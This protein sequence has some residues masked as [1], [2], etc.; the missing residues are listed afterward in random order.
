[1]GPLLDGGQTKEYKPIINYTSTVLQGILNVSYSPKNKLTLPILD[2]LFKDVSPS[3]LGVVLNYAPID[4]KIIWYSNL[5]ISG[6]VELESNQISL[7]QEY[8]SVEKMNICNDQ[9]NTTLENITLHNAMFFGEGK[10]SLPSSNVILENSNSGLYSDL[11]QN[12]SEDFY[13][14]LLHANATFQLSGKNQ[15]I[16]QSDV[17]ITFRLQNPAGLLVKCEQPILQINGTIDGIAKG[18]L[19]YNNVW[20]SANHER[21]TLLGEFRLEIAY[22]SNVVFSNMSEIKVLKIT[23]V[24]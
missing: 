9:E 8:L 21:I 24:K 20:Y 17:N 4:G 15:Q 14:N 7:S 11:F 12:G 10:I 5:S 18:L 16:S 13:V 22:S 3:R 6:N 1:M 23:F 2:N 19:I